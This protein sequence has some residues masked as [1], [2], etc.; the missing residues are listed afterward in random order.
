MT[1]NLH[2]ANEGTAILN[3][4]KYSAY[5]GAFHPTAEGHAAIA[6]AVMRHILSHNKLVP[7]AN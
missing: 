4:T 2:D 6:D 1:V 3:L 7:K 5:S